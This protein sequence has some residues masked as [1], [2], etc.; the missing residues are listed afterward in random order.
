MIKSPKKKSRAQLDREIAKS[1]ARRGH[2]RRR[3]KSAGATKKSIDADVD[4]DELI[5]SDDPAEWDVARD[6]A[7]Q[8]GDQEH[9]VQL[10]MAR[11][12]GEEPS[13]LRVVEGKPYDESFEVRLGNQQ[14][15]VVPDEDT[16]HEIALAR[17]KDDLEH[18]PQLFG[19]FI[20]DFINQKALKKWVYDARLEDDY[21]EELAARQI[22]DFWVLARALDASPVPFPT[23]EDGNLMK[24]TR[25]Q[26]AAV[27]KAYANEYANN[28]MSYFEDMYSHD[29]AVKQAIKAVGIDIKHAAEKALKTD[30][31]EHF[32][33]HYDGNSHTTDSGLVYWR[34]N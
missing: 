32:L 1:L 34:I 15:V 6:L 16:A 10:D 28:P 18:E 30:G 31:W 12:L 33:A 22:D 8:Q 25:K 5:A 23:D 20:E 19:S 29:E 11:A 21:V 17:V 2:A 7:L 4:I 13:L 3:G 14:Y 24:P 27:K 9:I 26:L